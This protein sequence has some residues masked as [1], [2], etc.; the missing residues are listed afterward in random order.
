[1]I[2]RKNSF[3]VTPQ[4][5]K[6]CIDWY[7]TTKKFIAVPATNRS[8]EAVLLKERSFSHQELLL[9]EGCFHQFHALAVGNSHKVK[10]QKS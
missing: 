6:R 4:N 7:S 5:F 1:M 2:F 8:R 9:L 10:S 3:L